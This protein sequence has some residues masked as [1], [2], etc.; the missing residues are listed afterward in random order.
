MKACRISDLDCALHILPQ[1]LI[2]SY[3]Q[4]LYYKL[5]CNKTFQIA[6]D[7]IKFCTG[8]TLYLRD[9]NSHYSGIPCTTQQ[10]FLCLS[11]E[12]SASGCF[13]KRKTRQKSLIPLLFPFPSCVTRELSCPKGNRPSDFAFQSANLLSVML[14]KDL[15]LE[16]FMYL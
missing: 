2:K 11:S 4:Q 14:H 6:L 12:T 5:K 15:V 13:S 7:I 9:Y 10:L 16:K 8:N 3:S 1:K